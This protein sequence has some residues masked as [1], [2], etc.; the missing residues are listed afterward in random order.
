VWPVNSSEV[1]QLY[2]AAW[3][4]PDEKERLR[5][6]TRCWTDDGVY[7]DPI[8]RVEGRPALVEHI[9]GYLVRQAGHRIELTS[10]VDRHDGYLRFA[11]VVVG[12]DGATVLA[13][14]NRPVPNHDRTGGTP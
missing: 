2:A 10:G 1:I 14:R 4:E 7:L 9:G 11:W 12:P 3:A 6:L 5:L 8:A 13:M